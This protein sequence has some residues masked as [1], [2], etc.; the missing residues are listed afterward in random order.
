[1]RLGW[2]GLAMVVACADSA[3]APIDELPPG[4]FHDLQANVLTK[5]CAVSGCHVAASAAS[6][7]GLSL[8][9]EAAWANL[10]GATPSMLSAK[11]DGLKRVRPG[12]PDS[13]LLYL[14]LIAPSPQSGK[15]YGN[16]MP[17][18]GALLSAGQLE[19]IFDPGIRG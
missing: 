11:Q 19:F 6:A 16:T 10:V 13:S 8:E 9:G 2:V 17:S 5:S 4:S 14:K 3:P 15:D 1:M 12:R 18:G 7:G